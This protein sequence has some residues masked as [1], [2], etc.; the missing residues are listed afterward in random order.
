MTFKRSFLAFLG[1]G[2]SR[3]TPGSD[4]RFLG[5]SVAIWGGVPCRVA[6]VWWGRSN[7]TRVGLMVRYYSP[8][9]TGGCPLIGADRIGA[10]SLD[11]LPGSAPP[12]I[13]LDAPGMKKAIGVSSKRYAPAAPY[14]KIPRKLKIQSHFTLTTLVWNHVKRQNLHFKANICKKISDS[15]MKS[16][17][18]SVSG[19]FL[20]NKKSRYRVEEY[21]AQRYLVGLHCKYAKEICRRDIHNMTLKYFT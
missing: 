9:D 13:G 2:P 4:R 1:A 19:K 18:W 6:P 3:R 11:R 20:E 17:I 16:G 21:E 10:W 8:T 12:R 15:D 14:P 5:R 7:R